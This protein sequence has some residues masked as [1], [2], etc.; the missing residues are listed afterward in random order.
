MLS[1]RGPVEKP[2]ISSRDPYARLAYFLT[3]GMML[4]GVA[5]G[6][7]RCWISWRDTPIISGRLC[8]VMDEEFESADEIFGEN[9]KFFREVDMSGFG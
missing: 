9:G 1:A 3:Y 8:M 4:V 6:A 7:I 2:W 5:A